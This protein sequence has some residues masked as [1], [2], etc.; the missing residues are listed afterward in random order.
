[1]KK[2]IKGKI[3]RVNRITQ[4]RFY[5][6]LHKTVKKMIKETKIHL[7]HFTKKSSV[8]EFFALDAND[9]STEA[10]D[11]L[12][13]LAY[14]FDD[15]FSEVV[16]YIPYHIQTIDDLSKRSTKRAFKKFGINTDHTTSE[17]SNVISAVIN[18]NVNYIKS[19]P[20]QYLKD[21]SGYVNRSIA[22]GGGYKDLLSHIDRIGAVTKRRAK[23]IALDQTR[24]AYNSITK[25]R[26][27]S[28]GVEKYEWI[29]SG[30]GA[31]PRPLHVSY[32]GQI[33]RFDDPPIIDER[34]KERGI[35][36]QAVN[37]KCTMR[38]VLDFEDLQ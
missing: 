16:G 5:R 6:L 32:D 34:T 18:D 10:K 26:L 17:L 25:Q 37:C 29:H 9:V 30:G 33:F 24:K 1:M 28:A 12:A 22:T 35:P 4:E 7:E 19:I 31:H 14:K 23:N 8:K 15:L 36:G 21:L 11:M 20:E 3:L 38:P 2:K 13:T 27:I